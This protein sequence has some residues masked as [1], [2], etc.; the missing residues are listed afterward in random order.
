MGNYVLS[1]SYGKDSIACLH[2]IEKLCLPLDR[3]IHAEVYFNDEISAD[4]PS[5]IDF[6]NYVDSFIF[7]ERGVE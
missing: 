6:K 3:V 4:L 1:L 2:A 5:V 7:Y